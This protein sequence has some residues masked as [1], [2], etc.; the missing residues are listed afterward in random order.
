MRRLIV[1]AGERC[2]L[3]VRNLA[4]EVDDEALVEWASCCGV[5][6]GATTHRNFVCI[7]FLLSRVSQLLMSSQRQWR[8]VRSPKLFSS[9]RQLT[10]WRDRM[11]EFS[12]VDAG[13]LALG[14]LNGLELCGRSVRL[15]R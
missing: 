2:R 11:I 1:G 9:M 7:C 3:A 14:K 13:E 5:V 6:C 15:Q 4:A 10:F 8:K 12:T